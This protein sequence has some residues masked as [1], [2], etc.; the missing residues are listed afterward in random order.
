M[1]DR[2]LSQF[3][4]IIDDWVLFR[5]RDPFDII[6]G[7]ITWYNILGFIYELIFKIHY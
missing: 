4:N 3:H 5:S 7:L 1:R 6:F 2:R